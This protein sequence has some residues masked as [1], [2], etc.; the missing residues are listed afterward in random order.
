MG[1]RVRQLRLSPTD[2][3]PSYRCV[4]LGGRGGTLT[5]RET[6]RDPSEVEE[7]VIPLPV[8]Q[9]PLL[10][11]TVFALGS[12]VYPAPCPLGPWPSWLQTQGPGVIGLLY[13]FVDLTD[14]ARHP[15]AAF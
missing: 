14:A 12:F 9:G 7:R 5:P 3:L 15:G 10:A 4:L 6:P 11:V 1:G 13:L 2:S 8:P